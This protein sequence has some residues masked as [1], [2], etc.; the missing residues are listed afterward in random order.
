MKR[1]ADNGLPHVFKYKKQLNKDWEYIA[2]WYLPCCYSNISRQAFGYMSAKITTQKH[3]NRFS[4][5]QDISYLQL[6]KVEKLAVINIAINAITHSTQLPKPIYT[7]TTTP[8][9]WRYN[10]LRSQ[11]RVYSL[12]RQSPL[13]E[14]QFK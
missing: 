4:T 9:T 1:K 2:T 12:L 6:L 11:L 8:S 3:I 5:P 7:N 14:A 10:I 13:E